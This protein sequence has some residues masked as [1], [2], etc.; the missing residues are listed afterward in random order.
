MTQ[1]FFDNNLYS[2]YLERLKAAGV[3]VRVIPGILPITSYE[4]L[5]KFCDIC[6]A[7]IS[8]EVHEIF[9]PLSG[10]DD[11]TRE[12]GIDFSVRQCKDLLDRGAPGIHFFSLNKVEP[13]QEIWKRP[14]I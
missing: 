3:N 12:A 6:G 14:E 13:T 8:D 11:A 9:K 1:L 7:T 5:V 10:D 2:E 4:G